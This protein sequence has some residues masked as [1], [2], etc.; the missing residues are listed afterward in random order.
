MKL[1]IPTNCESRTVISGTDRHMLTLTVRPSVRCVP[2]THNP[3]T[4]QPL[5]VTVTVSVAFGNVSIMVYG[6]KYKTDL[7]SLLHLY[8]L[9]AFVACPSICMS[10]GPSDHLHGCPRNYVHGLH[11]V[12]CRLGIGRF[13]PYFHVY[14]IGDWTVKWLVQSQWNHLNSLRLSDIY[15]RQ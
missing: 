13:Y 5:T 6:W 14:L 1:G 11:F 2:N 3:I 15:M 4:S 8:L 12:I 10:I 9:L 7:P